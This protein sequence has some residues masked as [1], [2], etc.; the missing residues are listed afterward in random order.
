MY[1]LSGVT[2]SLAILVVFKIESLLINLFRKLAQSLLTDVIGLT[3][4][5][6]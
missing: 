3:K 6:A 1:T 2:D 4:N 5:G